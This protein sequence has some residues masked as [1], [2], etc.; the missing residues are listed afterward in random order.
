VNEWIILALIFGRQ[1]FVY[2]EIPNCTGDAGR[3]GTRIEMV[4]RT[5]LRITFTDIAPGSVE[6]PADRRDQSHTCDDDASLIQCDSAVTGKTAALG[7]TA[8]R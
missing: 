7:K 4:D 8:R 1:V 6:L 3:V 2:I 5:N